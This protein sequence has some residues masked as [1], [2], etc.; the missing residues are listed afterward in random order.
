MEQLPTSSRFVGIDVSKD[1]LDVHV[2][3]SGRA[4]AVARNDKGLILLIGELRDLAPR[5]QA[6]FRKSRRT[7][8]LDIAA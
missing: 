3:L 4:F 7:G 2:R 6:A 8:P 5:H 1:C